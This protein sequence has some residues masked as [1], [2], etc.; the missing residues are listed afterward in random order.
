MC[1]DKGWQRV[2]EDALSTAPDPLQGRPQACT[3]Q[4]AHKRAFPSNLRAMTTQKLRMLMII[5]STSVTVQIR[6]P[7]P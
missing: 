4:A 7:L 6:S 3:L 1:V 5:C 2:Y